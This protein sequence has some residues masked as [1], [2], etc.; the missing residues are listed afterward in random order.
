MYSWPMD[1]RRGVNDVNNEED[2]DHKATDDDKLVTSVE[3]EGV[4]TI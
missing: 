1:A 2:V 3:R 4:E